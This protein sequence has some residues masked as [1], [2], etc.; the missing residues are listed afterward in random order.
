MSALGAG[1][2]PP[3]RERALW[4][5]FTGAVFFLVYG[6]S[7]AL[8]A[9]RGTS[10]S[11]DLP[12][13]QALP[14]MPWAVVP[15]MALDLLYAGAFALAASRRELQRLAGRVLLATAL[16]AAVFV[17]A[18]T[19][20]VFERPE[21][22][23]LPGAL[24]ALLVLDRPYNQC[25][26]LHV[27]LA[28]IVGQTYAARAAGVTRAA[29]VAL[30]GLIAVSTVLV[31]QH[32]VVDVAGG[33]MVAAI[34]CRLLPV[35]HDDEL[36]MPG[37]TPRSLRMALRYLG[38]CLLALLLLSFEHLPRVPLVWAATTTGVLALVYALG[39]RLPMATSSA[40]LRWLAGLLL[41]PYLVC[42]WLTWRWYRE[43]DRPLV[44]VVP[45]L[46]IGRR[47]T[48]AESVA[49]PRDVATVV[50]LAPELGPPPVPARTTRHSL[51]MLDLTI[52]EPAVLAT[53]VRCIDAG[54]AAGK[55][56]VLC[57]LG[58][59][60]SVMVAGAWLVAHGHGVDEALA[61]LRAVRPRAVTAGYVRV[62]LEEFAAYWRTSG[63][64]LAKAVS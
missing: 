49:L 14:F 60:R 61:Q 43:H 52:P 16:S 21:S 42:A 46:L 62:A 47:P 40:P 17:L 15:Y 29:L 25:P 8:A 6:G 44:E 51:P 45:G 24:F 63:A 57:T 11:L 30:F 48:A 41:A 32:H 10:A 7:N 19:R 39:W 1:S 3:A 64:H 36:P 37:S 28:V 23:G 33:L 55:V 35:R 31:W 38:L 34:V 56:L 50:D 9:W 59:A 27:S 4:V 12:W 54:R 26:S 5:V 2:R 53:A 20:V 58:Y 18:P 13:E 22:G